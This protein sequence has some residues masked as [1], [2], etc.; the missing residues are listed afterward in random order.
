[1]LSLLAEKYDALC[2]HAAGPPAPPSCAARHH[3]G[4]GRLSASHAAARHGSWRRPPDR[5][6]AV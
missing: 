3:G 2:G 6:A 1:M 4:R 5:H